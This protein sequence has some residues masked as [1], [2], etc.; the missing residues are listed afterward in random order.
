MKNL[1][2]ISFTLIVLFSC[3]RKSEPTKEI[4][5]EQPEGYVEFIDNSVDPE[6]LPPQY[7]FT[8]SLSA[9][10]SA[11]IS[12]E[13][14]I[15]AVKGTWEGEMGGK[16][17]TIVIEKI[18]GDQISGY[19]IVGNNKRALKGKISDSSYDQACAMAFEAVL[20]EPGDD[21][22]DGVFSLKFVGYYNQEYIDD[23]EFECVGDLQGY[24][25]SGEWV[26]N[27]GKPKKTLT[28]TKQN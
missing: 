23:G 7:L 14:A 12:T 3:G 15:S 16:K 5:F 25:A 13:E 2:I 17:I 9:S 27:N 28:L 4:V 6:L 1:N 10:S 21:K 26:P 11:A 8:G 22:W 19:N 18:Q 24:D 20:N